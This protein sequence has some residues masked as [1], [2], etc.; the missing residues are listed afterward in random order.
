MDN[1]TARLTAAAVKTKAVGNVECDHNHHRPR[2]TLRLTKTTRPV[3]Y[4]LLVY[5]VPWHHCWV[6]SRGR[7]ATTSNIA[8][9]SPASQN[10]KRR[11]FVLQRPT[12]R[13]GSTRRDRKTRKRCTRAKRKLG[14][15]YLNVPLVE[16]K[17]LRR[18]VPRRCGIGNETIT[19]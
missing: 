4:L 12:E 18:N 1:S 8:Y 16:G 14:F 10:K 19:N 15:N 2:N 11:I 9:R 7:Q 3:Q 13:Q 6:N 5:R 17:H